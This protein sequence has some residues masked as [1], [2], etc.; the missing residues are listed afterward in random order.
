M[1]HTRQQRDAYRAAIDAVSALHNVEHG[2]TREDVERIC[3]ELLTLR[4]GPIV[5]RVTETRPARPH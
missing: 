5:G 1:K 3:D 2:D 4:Y